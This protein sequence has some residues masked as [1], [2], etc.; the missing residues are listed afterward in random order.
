MNARLQCLHTGATRLHR[1]VA[2]KASNAK[3]LVGGNWKCNGTQESVRKLVS[4]LNAGKVPNDIEV[5]VAPVFIHIK[6]VIDTLQPPI[7]VGAQNCWSHGGG[8]FTGEV[9]ANMLADMGVPWVISGHSERRALCNETNDVVG[10]K[11]AYAIGAGLNVIACVG[12]SLAQRESGELWNVLDGQMT[13]LKDHVA[14]EDWDKLVI[15]YEPIWAIGT[16]VVAS[17][18]QAQVRYVTPELLP[19]PDYL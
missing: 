2:C 9:T 8:A 7:R 14:S 3:F 6:Q 18:A 15:A 11:T 17:P 1:S 12:E 5:V 10:D 19:A 13:S 16:G 4:G